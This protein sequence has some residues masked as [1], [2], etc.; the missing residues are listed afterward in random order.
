VLLRF[1]GL[2][3]FLEFKLN[4]HTNVVPLD[5]SKAARATSGTSNAFCGDGTDV[6]HAGIRDERFPSV[7][8][9]IIRTDKGN[10]T[11]E[12]C[13]KIL[14]IVEYVVEEFF[15]SRAL[16][17]ILDRFTSVF[18]GAGEGA[19]V[20]ETVAVETET[21]AVETEAVKAVKA[22]AA[23]VDP[24]ETKTIAVETEVVDVDPAKVKAVKD[25]QFDWLKICTRKSDDTEPTEI[26]L[27]EME[28]SLPKFR[29]ILFN[30][31]LPKLKNYAPSPESRLMDNE[32][33]LRFGSS[34]SQK[35]FAPAKGED[36]TFLRGTGFNRN[37]DMMFVLGGSP[38]LR[39]RFT[40]T[41][42]GKVYWRLF[43][44]AHREYLGK[45][46]GSPAEA[47]STREGIVKKL[48]LDFHNETGGWF[49]CLQSDTITQYSCNDVINRV[50]GYL[51]VADSKSLVAKRPNP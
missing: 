34:R 23:Y 11:Q 18:G 40:K 26:E 42:G 31:L 21:I 49:F 44:E 39:A 37:I 50:N 7:V 24:V 29:D 43:A 3:N 22:E 32:L 15:T 30:L 28:S 41:P 36:R 4:Q 47:L 51:A 35:R 6:R 38:T 13:M 45:K 33:M 5:C 19:E 16:R 46:V 1:G 20:V 25:Q 9:Q 27:C 8:L 10:V 17:A 2:L 14:R 12:D 48:A